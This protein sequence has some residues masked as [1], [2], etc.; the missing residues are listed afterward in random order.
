[1]ERRNFLKLVGAVPLAGWLNTDVSDTDKNEKEGISPA[2]KCDQCIISSKCK[3]VSVN[4]LGEENDLL[5]DLPA[6][7]SNNGFFHKET[8]KCLN[9][10]ND[11]FLDVPWGLIK[12]NQ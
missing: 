4:L 7:D 1:M 9:R 8:P 2:G 6:I 12:N 5:K 10:E 11:L 3:Q